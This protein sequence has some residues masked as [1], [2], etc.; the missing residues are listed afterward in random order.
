MTRS[1]PA[2]LCRI[3]HIARKVSSGIVKI[4]QSALT[5]SRSEQFRPAIV[6]GLSDRIGGDEQVFSLFQVL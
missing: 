5:G 4:D 2:I 1:T 3:A 6:E